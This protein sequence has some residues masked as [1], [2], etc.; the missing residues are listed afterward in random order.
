MTLRED[1]K[2][3]LSRNWN[4]KKKLQRISIEVEMGGREE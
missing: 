2:D 3:I 1:I 4:N